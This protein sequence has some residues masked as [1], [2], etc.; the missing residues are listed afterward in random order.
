MKQQ[1]KHTAFHNI[2]FTTKY[3]YMNSEYYND[4]T[5]NSP[6]KS[7]NGYVFVYILNSKFVMYV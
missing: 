1:K 7:S 6:I 5:T 2:N 3:K 4:D